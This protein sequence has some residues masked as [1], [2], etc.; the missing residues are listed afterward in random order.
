MPTHIYTIK[1]SDMAE[2]TYESTIG[3]AYPDDKS[4]GEAIYRWWHAESKLNFYARYSDAEA[5]NAKDLGYGEPE[6]AFYA[7][8]G[9]IPG[10]VPIFRF[11]DQESGDHFYCLDPNGEGSGYTPES[12]GFHLFSSEVA[13]TKAVSRGRYGGDLYCIALQFKSKTVP[14]RY[15]TVRALSY[16]EASAV[17]TARLGTSDEAKFFVTQGKCPFEGNNPDGFK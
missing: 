7:P 4:N 3:F 13:N 9:D 14:Y 17:A 6:I 1:N 12:I 16:E 5:K 10:V 11:W 15:E 8:A 2:Y